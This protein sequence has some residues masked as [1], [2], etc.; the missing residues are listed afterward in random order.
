MI[1]Q[2]AVIQLPARDPRVPYARLNKAA[3]DVAERNPEASIVRPV[4]APANE[5]DVLVELTV[6]GQTRVVV[7][8]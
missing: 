8:R 1:G 7:P 6:N 2:Q 4:W 5:V 3:R